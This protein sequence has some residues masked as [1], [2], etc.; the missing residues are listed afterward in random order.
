[1]RIFIYISFLP[2]V[3]ASCQKSISNNPYDVATPKSVFTPSELSVRQ[4]GEN[5]LLNWKQENINISGF[6]LF[7]SIDRGAFEE[8]VILNKSIL[9]YTDTLIQGGKTYTYTL[10][11]YADKNESNEVSTE[12]VAKSRPTINTIAASLITENTATSGGTIVS[13]GGSPITAKGLVWSASVNPIVDLTTKTNDGTGSATFERILT[14]LKANTTYYVRAYAV[15]SIGTS[16]GQQIVFNTEIPTNIS[17]QDRL[18]LGLIAYYPFSGN[19]NDESGNNNHGISNQVIA[20]TD[21]KGNPNS[22]F[23]FNG[24]S[25]NIRIEKLSSIDLGD[26]KFSISMWI[27]TISIDIYIGSKIF[28]KG[29]NSLVISTFDNGTS[30]LPNSG[31]KYGLG[32]DSYGKNYGIYPDILDK[33]GWHFIVCVKTN[34]GYDYYINNKKYSLPFNDM[35]ISKSDLNF[36][37]FLGSRTNIGSSFNGYL[38]DIRIYNRALTQEEITYLAN[39]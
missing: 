6:K 19:A 25:S 12:I 16:Y 27:N 17:I 15:N 22:C 20:S 14:N 5:L 8:L 39:N 3:I 13:D 2:F 21:R 10:K 36:P 30:G 37:L 9:S 1:M 23:L 11:A 29:T 26:T 33:N 18:A 31:L 35:N 32:W 34:S 4:E 24:D 28:T 38:D 7:R